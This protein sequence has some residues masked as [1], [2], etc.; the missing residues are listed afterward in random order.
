MRKQSYLTENSTDLQNT[1]FLLC[2]YDCNAFKD[3]IDIK[4]FGL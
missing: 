4:K 1:W 3:S 2:V